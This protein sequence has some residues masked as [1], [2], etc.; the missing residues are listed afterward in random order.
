MKPITLFATLAAVLTLACPLSQAA[1]PVAGDIAPNELGKT[2]SGDKVLL[3][4]YAGK[5]VI[6]SFWATWCGYCLKEL[7]VLEGIQKVAGAKH[8]LQVIAVNTEDR[9][10]FRFVSRKLSTLTLG[11]AYDPQNIGQA[12]YGVK[13]IPHLVIIGRDGVIIRVYR[14]YGEETLNQITDDINLAIGATGT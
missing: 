11:M 9:D 1:A 5:V 10:T 4:N 7:P 14:G 13:G 6:V 2:L 12:A 3:S 8:N